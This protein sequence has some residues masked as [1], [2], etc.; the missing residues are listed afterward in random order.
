MQATF[1][2]IERLWRAAF[3]LA[4]A[5]AVLIVL[6]ACT[7]APPAPTLPD[8]PPGNEGGQGTTTGDP[9]TPEPAAAGMIGRSTR[10]R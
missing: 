10:R 8:S 4:L 1:L 3:C 5:L 9:S 6:S 2:N 7:R